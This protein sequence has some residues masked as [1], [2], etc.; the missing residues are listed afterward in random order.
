MDQGQYLFNNQ[1]YPDLLDKVY[2][3]VQE[4]TWEHC[5]NIQ[6]PK[7]QHRILDGHMS[8]FKLDE[9]LNF[10]MGFPKGSYT[11]FIK[12][13]LLQGNQKYILE[14]FIR[15]KEMLT[16]RD[17]LQNDRFV[18]QYIFHMA[19]YVFMNLKVR[20][21]QT[22]SY[23]IIP[24]DTPDGVTSEMLKWMIN[25][26]D[27]QYT[28]NRWCLEIRPKVSYIY[29]E[30]HI[31]DMIVDGNRIY[32]DQFTEKK[33]YY[34]SDEMIE[35]KVCMSDSTDN[36]N[37]LRMSTGLLL[38]DD[39]G[40]GYLEI[41]DLYYEYISQAT[42][43]LRCFAFNEGMK[44]GYTI[45]PNYIGPTVYLKTVF[46]EYIATVNANRLKVVA[47]T[48]DGGFQSFNAFDDQFGY[49]E[50]MVMVGFDPSGNCWVSIPTKDGI[51]PIDPRSFRVWEYDWE[52][53]TIGRLVCQEME[54]AFPNIYKYFMKSECKMLYIEWFRDDEIKGS[55]YDDFTREYREYLGGDFYVK[56]IDKTIIQ[57]LRDFVPQK[58][59]YDSG[60]FITRVVLRGSNDYRRVKMNEILNETS[61]HWDMLVNALDDYNAIFKTIVIRMEEHPEIYEAIANSEDG[62]GRIYINAAYNRIC[63]YD[64]YIDGVHMS[65]GDSSTFWDIFKQYIVFPAHYVK[66]DSVLILDFYEYAEHIEDKVWLQKTQGASLLNYNFPMPKVSGYDLIPTLPDGTRIP[67]KDVTYGLHAIRMDIQ[68][69]ETTIKWEGTG[70][71]PDDL[72]IVSRM[73]ED[74][75][76]ANPPFQALTFRYIMPPDPA[77]LYLKTVN[78]EA[79]IGSDNLYLMVKNGN[80]VVEHD[81]FFAKRVNACDLSV[82]V[83]G[84]M[85]TDIVMHNANVKRMVSTRRLNVEP[86]IGI[87]NFCGADDPSRI[88]VFINGKLLEEDQYDGQIPVSLY[89]DLQIHLRGTFNDSD[90]ASLVYLPFSAERMDV[91]SD[92]TSF[93]HLEGTGVRLIGRRDMIFENGYR[94]PNESLERITNMLIR[95]PQPNTKYT[96]IR[97]KKDPFFYD[98]H[99]E[100][101]QSITDKMLKQ[102]PGWCASKNVYI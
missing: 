80:I 19:D 27:N 14:H 67:L 90:L 23:L 97:Q 64:F 18:N 98:Y 81:P 55:N 60:D 78:S 25:D 75:T 1:F 30:K 57:C 82:K 89:R 71:G 91:V 101:L 34:R 9:D 13:R 38:F 74:P 40:R 45:S 8:D 47:M 12:E 43:A 26:Y 63:E 5:V 22:G 35:W 94:I 54:V 65:T 72:E 41:S 70:V 44:A 48:V 21:V 58:F 32:L 102:S 24:V 86:M 3:E 42:F 29:G 53:D 69:P 2:H 61:R 73:G 83:R 7:T 50:N 33:N 15:G 52:A 92:A 51:D 11:H 93:I 46:D 36:P 6:S 88:L 10:R 31:S 28:S 37:L 85:E 99:D 49:A 59:I 100:K 39:A 96:I 84:L 79:L 68:V 16:L 56:T 76:V 95:A 17:M 62:K 20:V 87:P 77:Y 66:P 4:T